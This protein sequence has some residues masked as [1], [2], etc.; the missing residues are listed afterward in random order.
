MS[1]AFNGVESAFIQALTHQDLD[2]D[3]E[4]PFGSKKLGDFFDD[5]VHSS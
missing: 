3:I 1:S 4:S 5:F 2:I